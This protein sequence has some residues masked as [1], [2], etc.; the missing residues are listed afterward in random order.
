MAGAPGQAQPQQAPGKHCH[1]LLQ[2]VEQP[3]VGG[4][5]PRL[6]TAPAL[7]PPPARAY[8]GLQTHSCFGYTG[9]HAPP[10][11][12]AH[13]AQPLPHSSSS[14]PCLEPG[15]QFH[16]SQNVLALPAHTAL[17][18]GLGGRSSV[19]LAAAPHYRAAAPQPIPASQGQVNLG[20]NEKGKVLV[21]Q[22]P[23]R[24]L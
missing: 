2:P 4:H 5:T 17:A 16:S 10:R 1:H 9:S 12:G 3:A 6:S 23:F 7:P 14:F 22:L 8:P 15:T 24:S 13:I 18:Q 21:L 11:E 19:S 20:L